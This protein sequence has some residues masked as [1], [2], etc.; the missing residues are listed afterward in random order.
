MISFPNQTMDHPDDVRDRVK[1]ESR[2]RAGRAGPLDVTGERS[3]DLVDQASWESFP[4]SD[5]PPWTL[6]YVGP[7]S[8]PAGARAREPGVA[9]R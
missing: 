6:G 8:R 5:A 2:R 7:P 1:E 3:W 4:A 9:S